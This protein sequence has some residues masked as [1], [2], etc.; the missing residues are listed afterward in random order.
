MADVRNDHN[1]LIPIDQP[2][3]LPEDVSPIVAYQSERYGRDGHSHSYLSLSELEGIT[4][5]EKLEFIQFMRE[6]EKLDFVEDVRLVFWF[7]N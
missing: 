3:D 7:D 6:L 2:R 5:N 1:E 4:T